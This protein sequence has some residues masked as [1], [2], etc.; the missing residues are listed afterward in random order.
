MATAHKA[1]M[2]GVKGDKTMIL[3]EKIVNLRKR[4]GWSQEE[5]SEQLDVSRQSV[6]KWESAQSIPDMDK[7]VKMSTVFGVTTDYLLKDEL[8]DEEL[9]QPTVQTSEPGLRKVTLEE[10]SK[11]ME[12][13]RA[14]APRLAL[15]S[16]MC[17]AAPILLILLSSLAEY[18]KISLREETTA[19]IGLIV[20]FLMIALAAVGFIRCSAKVS[21][22]AFLD[23]E[24]FETEYGVSNVVKKKRDDFKDTATRINTISTAT[25]ILAM[26]PLF[27]ALCFNPQDIVY[28][29]AVCAMLF[30]IA[31]GVFGFVYT[32]T[33]NGSYNKLLEDGDFTRENKAM[34]KRMSGFSTVYWLLM[35]AVSMTLMFIGVG[36]FWIVYPIAGVLFVPAKMLYAAIRK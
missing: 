3:A 9:G 19:G 23:N 13:R 25:V 12:V 31:C 33:I 34:S 35:V 21:E 27:L 10:A 30:M 29:Y 17:V 11:Y 7:I 18:G 1:R 32:G 36:R 15:F 4:M 20:M 28:V 5:L 6:S 24:N 8:G 16:S 14:N 22:F 26:V 2:R